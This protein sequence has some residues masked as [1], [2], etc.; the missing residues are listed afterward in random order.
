MLDR[1]LNQN[2][3]FI[4]KAELFYKVTVLAVRQNKRRRK[5]FHD[6]FYSRPRQLAVNRS[7]AASA[8]NN[9][10][11]GGDGHNVSSGENRYRVSVRSSFEKLGTD[12]LRQA[13]DLR[14]GQRAFLIGISNFFIVFFG[15]FFKPLENIYF[16][17]LYLLYN[18]FELHC[19]LR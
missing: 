11:K 5:R 19:L 7:V 13:F 16:H 6:F 2:D 10:E 12:A 1:V 15:R 9:A 14:K 3:F 17:N 8:V 18:T 4:A